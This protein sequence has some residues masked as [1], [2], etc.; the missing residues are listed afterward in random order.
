M[1]AARAVIP[2]RAEGLLRTVMM[3]G[4]VSDA[5]PRPVRPLPDDFLNALA[6][7]PES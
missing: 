7:L 1:L 2:H 4:A 5:A 6:A 3:R